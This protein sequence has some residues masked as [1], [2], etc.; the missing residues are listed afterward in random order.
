MNSTVSILIFFS[1]L[2][3]K[4]SDSESEKVFGVWKGFYGTEN[5][6][7]E[8]VIRIN[9]QN[10]AEIFCSHADACLSTIG[11]YKLLGDTAIIISA[12]LTDSK[13]S[14][15]VLYGNLNRTASFMDG[16]WDGNGKEKGCFYLQKQPL[17]PAW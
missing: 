14:E 6:L 11:S 17:I 13:T 9:P 16:E 15:V 10:K 5:E 3:F 7:K 8:I 2:F 12:L 4:T 1:S